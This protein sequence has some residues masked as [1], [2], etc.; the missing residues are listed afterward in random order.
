MKILKIWAE[1]KMFPLVPNG[2][3]WFPFV[4]GAQKVVP[5][6]QGSKE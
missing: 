4:N 6:G 5:K 1:G 2:T 3:Q